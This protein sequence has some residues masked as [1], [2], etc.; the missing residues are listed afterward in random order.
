VTQE[1]VALTRRIVRPWSLWGLFG[2][3][4]V[5]I[6]ALAPAVAATGSSERSH[7]G[8]DAARSRT[9]TPAARGAATVAALPVAGPRQVT[10]GLSRLFTTQFDGSPYASGNCNMA[11]GAMLFEVQTGRMVTGA[12][13]RRWSGARTQGT[14]LLDLRRAFGR[15]GQWVQ[16]AEDM[17]WESFLGE[18]RSGR[19][20]VVQGWYGNLR[21][22]VLQAGFT[23]A[24]SVFVLGY[25]GHAL[26]GR[27][28]FYVMDPLGMGGYDG[29][30]WSRQELRRFGWSGSPSTVGTGRSAFYG[31]VALQA[32]PSKKHLSSRAYRPAFQSYWDTSKSL[33]KRSRN[34][35]LVDRRP[36]VPAFVLRVE[37]P[38]LRL[39][40]AAAKR[41]DLRLPLQSW[42]QQA[43]GF[44]INDKRLIVRTSPLAKVTAAATGRVIYRGWTLDGTKTLWIQHGPSLST[45]YKGLATTRVEPGHWVRAGTVLGKV[46]VHS[47]GKSTKRQKWGT[48]RFVVSV[49]NPRQAS[50]RQ[51]PLPFLGGS[52]GTI[53]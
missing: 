48:F 51:F 5:L 35:N 14:N 16:I 37:D 4:L 7:A 22:N 29:A 1:H 40:A 17:R 42:N 12:Q 52:N 11:A 23:T 30:W 20:A 47:T 36:G 28:G 2:L 8:R 26:K 45:I 13:M 38:K 6:I 3:L 18:V 24:H 34:V 21:S 50:S 39:T 27:G 25:S 44:R 46:D 49:G 15:G 43:R 10:L 32:G 53:H 31:N 41:R 33:M 9:G 19:S